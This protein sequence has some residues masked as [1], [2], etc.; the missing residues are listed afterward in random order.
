MTHSEIDNFVEKFFSLLR[1]NTKESKYEASNL[2]WDFFRSC[3]AET[4]ILATV[5]LVNATMSDEELF[6]IAAGELEGAVSRMDLM[7]PSATDLFKEKLRQEAKLRE[8]MKGVWMTEGAPGE[9]I[10]HTICQK[11]GVVYTRLSPKNP[12]PQ[13]SKKPKKK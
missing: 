1:K 5:A 13:K 9:D 11:H 7:P 8:G 2:S 3:D 4:K 10:L 6:H 12:P